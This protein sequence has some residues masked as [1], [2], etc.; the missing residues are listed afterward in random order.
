MIV[1]KKLDCKNIVH[2]RLL[3]IYLACYRPTT[4]DS[5]V[6]KYKSSKRLY[7]ILYINVYK[8]ILKH[9]FIYFVLYVIRSKIS[10]K[11]NE[12]SRFHR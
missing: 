5:F 6:S 8:H 11:R 4:H 9:K 2:V 7:H 12:G 3:L 10:K 1:I